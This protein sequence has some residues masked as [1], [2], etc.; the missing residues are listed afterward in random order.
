VLAIST[1]MTRLRLSLLSAALLA[2]CT[3]GPDYAPRSAA[4]LGVPD[5]YSVTAAP[6][7]EDLTHWWTRF[8]DPV[9]GRLVEQASTANTDLAQSQA[10]LRQ[11]RES[12]IQSRAGLLPTL[13]GSGGYSR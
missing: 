4:E 9:L 1:T 8:D 10:R 7:R 11:A 2:G 13:N 6:T 5:A 3:V 12:L